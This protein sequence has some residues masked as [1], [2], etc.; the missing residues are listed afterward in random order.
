MAGPTVYLNGRFVDYDEAKIPVEDRGMQFADGVY[1]VVRYYGGRPFRM[2][3]HLERLGRSAAGLDLELPPL[4]E[5]ERAM[6]SLVE[7]A[8]LSE[9]TVYLQITRGAAPRQ[10]GLVSGVAPTVIA[11]PRPATSPRPRPTLK[12]ITVSDDRWARCYL[13]T[14]ALLPNAMARE[15]ARRLGCDDAIFVRDGF[16]MEASSSNVFVVQ[17]GRLFTPTLTNYILAGVTRG[18]ILDL[19]AASGIPVSEE[20]VSVDRVYQADE[21]FISGT[22]SELGPVVEV[23]G[24]AIGDRRPGPIF[25]TLLAAFDVAVG[26]PTPVTAGSA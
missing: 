3:Q 16:L 11:I 7:R 2:A 6:N 8:G 14:T 18:A 12:V 10:H 21:V 13:K 20:P 25:E 19:A 26:L 5:I 23:D 4:D 22:N 15:R 9:A 17:G 1:E 24:R